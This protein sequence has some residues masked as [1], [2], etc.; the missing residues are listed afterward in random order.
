MN[1]KFASFFSERL[2]RKKFNDLG[3]IETDLFWQKEA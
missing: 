1:F 2:F 3:N